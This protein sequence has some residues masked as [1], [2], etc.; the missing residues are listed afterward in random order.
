M[1]ENDPRSVFENDPP[2]LL[3]DAF[4]PL[5]QAHK[6][7]THHQFVLLLCLPK[8]FSLKPWKWGIFEY[9]GSKRWREMKRNQYQ[10]FLQYVEEKG[11]KM[12][13][14]TYFFNF[15]NFDAIRVRMEIWASF[16]GKL[17]NSSLSLRENQWFF[18]YFAR[19][20]CSYL[21]SCSFGLWLPSQF[22]EFRISLS[23]L[24]FYFSC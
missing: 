16:L 15:V 5:G 22:G 20:P 7:K 2:A 24:L 1:F 17:G 14:I 13:M 4:V 10:L 23:Q 12:K 8:G 19:N 11:M 3:K 21:G 18:E 6:W 9:P